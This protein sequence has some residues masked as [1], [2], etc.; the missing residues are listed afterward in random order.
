MNTQT[1]DNGGIRGTG[2]LAGVVGMLLL[3]SVGLELLVHQVFG[4]T[5]VDTLLWALFLS[6]W[7]CILGLAGFLVVS[8]QWF[9]DWR[10]IRTNQADING[11]S[12]PTLER[13][14]LEMTGQEHPQS[15]QQTCA[16]PGRSFEKAAVGHDTNN[17]N[18]VA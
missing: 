2:W 15:V 3:T 7:T 18:K 4:Q 9:L 16:A 13:S 10:R 6:F 14:R 8:L 17:L 1:Q 5:D 11:W 12:L